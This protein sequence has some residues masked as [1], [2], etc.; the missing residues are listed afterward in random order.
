MNESLPSNSRHCW[1]QTCLAG[2]ELPQVVTGLQGLKHF[3]AL[4]FFFFLTE[5][6]VR[7]CY[8]KLEK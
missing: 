6:L 7:Y 3:Y 8:R 4:L 2:G 1:S 5:K